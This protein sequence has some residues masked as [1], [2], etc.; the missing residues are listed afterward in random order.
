M[1]AAGHVEAVPQTMTSFGEAILSQRFTFFVYRLPE[2]GEK[3]VSL[4]EMLDL[5]AL[6]Q[7]ALEKCSP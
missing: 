7:R 1:S 3:F 4:R 2:K 6:R 5:F